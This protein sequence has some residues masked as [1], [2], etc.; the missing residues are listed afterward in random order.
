M[1]E[2]IYLYDI[3]LDGMCVG[4]SGDE[5]FGSEREAIADAHDYIIS[6]LEHEYDRHPKE[7]EVKVYERI[8]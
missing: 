1:N 8:V 6:E 7:F 5:E 4:D 2:K 3:F